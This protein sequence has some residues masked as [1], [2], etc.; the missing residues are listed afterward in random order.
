MTE[1]I[2]NNFCSKIAQI[3]QDDT[4]I[5][6]IISQVLEFTDEEKKTL[7]T[8]FYNKFANVPNGNTLL[9]NKKVKLF[10]SKEEE[11][12]ALS[13]S[14]FGENL[15]LKKIFNNLEGKEKDYMWMSLKLIIEEMKPK[16]VKN[17]LLN[18]EV[19]SNVNGLIDDIIKQFKE[20]MNKKNAD[21]LQSILSITGSITEK[22]KDKFE[23]GE[24]Q[25]QSLV[26]ELQ[27]KMPFAKDLMGSIL[28]KKE[29]KEEVKPVIID[30]NFTTENIQVGENKP[31]ESNFNLSKMLPIMKG[32]DKNISEIFGSDLDM[33]DLFSMVQNPDEIDEEKANDIGEKMG[34]LMKEKFNLNLQ[35]LMKDDKIAN[36][37]KEFDKEQHE[38][39]E[40]QVENKE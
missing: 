39:Q 22:Y 12:H 24:I 26:D 19:D 11:T 32:L 40:Q 1:N 16:K 28:P 5:T 33:K 37:F 9:E 38:Q 8:N 21:P 2:L 7:L 36:M 6:E 30:E 10:S 20:T 25:L 14:L 13:I 27:E 17:P 35:D 18:M 29:K 3:F 34:N 31:E 23:S 4:Y 15:P